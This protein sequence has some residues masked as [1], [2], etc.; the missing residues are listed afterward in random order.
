[1]TRAA[2]YAPRCKHCGKR[3]VYIAA[4]EAKCDGKGPLTPQQ[5]RVVALFNEG[6]TYAE[7]GKRA[8]VSPDH[9]STVLS[10]ARAKG[11]H[12]P[13]RV[14]PAGGRPRKNPETAWPQE[15][16]AASARKPEPTLWTAMAGDE[17]KGPYHP[18]HDNPRMQRIFGGRT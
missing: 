15:R 13:Y 12:A 8:G 16:A 17:R 3:F 18:L 9:V 4:H 7:I 6:L 14:G 1:M 2:Q 5:Q 11:A 10:H